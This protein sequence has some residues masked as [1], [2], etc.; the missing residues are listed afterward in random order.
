LIGR[1]KFPLHAGGFSAILFKTETKGGL[2]M[3]FERIDIREAGNAVQLIADDWALL[4]AGDSDH[5]NTMTISWGGIGQLWGFSCAFVFVRPQR[6]TLQFIEGS[7]CFTLSFGLPRKTLQFC[8][9][10]SGRDCD[11]IK[12]AGLTA[13]SEGAAVWPEEAQLVLLCRKAAVQDL[14]PAG[15]LDETIA[16]NYAEQDYH[17]MFVGEILQVYR[18]A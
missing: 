18:K 6:H 15:F 7:D 11:K 2:V 16:R 5:W 12:E 8:G 1:Q 4:S 17:K 13:C 9:S 14:D 10:V 3:P